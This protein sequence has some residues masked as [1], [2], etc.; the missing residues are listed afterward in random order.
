M[1]NQDIKTIDLLEVIKHIWKSKF[2]IIICTLL[3]AGAGFF[4]S[5]SEAPLYMTSVW[6][7]LPQYVDTQ[8]VNTAVQAANGNMLINLYKQVGMNP[9]SPTVSVSAD[10]LNKST[11]IRIQFQGTNPEE[12]QKFS[13]TYKEA[14]VNEINKF[15]NEK[16]L[17]D[18]ENAKLQGNNLSSVSNFNLAKAEVIKD[19]AVPTADLNAGNVT[20]KIIK[21]TILGF[22]IGL[23]IGLLRYGISVVRKDSN[24]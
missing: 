2:I 6:V 1:E 21:M 3:F 22:I 23:G 13:D 19:G 15:V 7:R 12:I 14:Y 24:N 10:I 16:A 11:V 4:L 20:S 18:L 17:T 8:T 9:D 5:R